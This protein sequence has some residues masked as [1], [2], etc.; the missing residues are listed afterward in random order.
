MI[1]PPTASAINHLLEQEP[2]ARAKLARHAGKLALFDAGLVALRLAVTPDGM[3]EAGGADSRPDVTIRVALADIPLILQDR[4]HAFSYVRIEGDADFA[5]TISQLSE[6]LR[7]EA[8]HDLARVF[9]DVPAMRLV[10][11][12]RFAAQ[13]AHTARL[14]LE[15][16]LAEYFL[17]ENPMLASSAAVSEFGDEINRL[18]DDAERL[19]KRI[20]KLEGRR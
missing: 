18:R 11:G 4:A 8:E 7:W 1:S 19:A 5:N 20:E 17:E 6:N 9:G 13:S 16:N 2:W 3:V 10:A 14:R 15:E 12:L